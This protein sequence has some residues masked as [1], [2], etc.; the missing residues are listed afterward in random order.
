MLFLNVGSWDS[1]LKTDSVAL[2]KTWNYSFN[3][4]PVN[5]GASC[6]RVHSEKYW[7]DDKKKKDLSDVGVLTVALICN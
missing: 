2:D 5:S 7:Y 3:K 6:L 4:Q 1:I